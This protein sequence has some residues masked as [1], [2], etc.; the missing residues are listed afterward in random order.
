MQPILF[1]LSVLGGRVEVGSYRFFL[2]LAAI[3]GVLLAGLI[4]KRRS[5]AS[6]QPLILWLSVAAAVP[7]GARLLHAVTN[8]GLYARDPGR[9]FSLKATG[10][11]LFGG[12]LLAVMVGAIVCRLLKLDL[13]RLADSAAPALGISIA[14]V[15]IGCF[16][17]GCCAGKPSSLPWAVIFPNPTA[18]DLAHKT[19][20]LPLIGGA[21]RQIAAKPAAMHPVDL[22]ELIA[23]AIGVAL[24]VRL[25][26]RRTPDGVVFLGFALWFSAF[27][28]V[29]HPLR[30]PSATFIGPAWFYPGLYVAAI[31]LSL[32]MLQR[33]LSGYAEFDPRPATELSIVSPK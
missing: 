16:L 30:V 15:R 3:A 27:R 32:A 22:Y 19:G 33:R 31:A 17:D 4:A 11:A 2:I 24:A 26:K 21:L 1:K 23:A 18:D 5:A 28:L 14:L 10:F 6:G 25:I 29:N 8:Y 20:S 12:L 7:V 9:F 13:W